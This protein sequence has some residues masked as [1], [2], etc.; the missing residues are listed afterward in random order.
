MLKCIVLLFVVQ[1]EFEFSEFEFELNVFESF[2]KKRRQNLSFL[3]LAFS[4]AHLPLPR[5]SSPCGPIPPDHLLPSPAR[6]TLPL[7][8][9][10]RRAPPVRRLLLPELGLSQS[11]AAPRLAR[12]VARTPRG[13]S[14]L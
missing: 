8:L 2:P 9:T 1:F 3:S 12:A 7:T 11:P 13:P 5:F 6:S 14:A 10:A 4:P